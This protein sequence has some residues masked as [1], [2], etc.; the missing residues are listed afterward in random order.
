MLWQLQDCSKTYTA[1]IS[2][3]LAIFWMQSFMMFW[4]G[5][6]DV[7]RQKFSHYVPELHDVELNSIMALIH[8]AKCSFHA[9]RHTHFICIFIKYMS[10][11][12][13]LL[14]HALLW[15]CKCIA[16]PLHIWSSSPYLLHTWTQKTQNICIGSAIFL[17]LHAAQAK[18]ATNLRKVQ[19]RTGLF[20]FIPLNSKV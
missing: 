15:M 8:D 6:Y 4:H 14:M 12:S 3:I 13:A 7:R 10:R 18:N 11:E 5:S 2:N 1:S 19:Y 9:G 16:H 17:A 20:Y